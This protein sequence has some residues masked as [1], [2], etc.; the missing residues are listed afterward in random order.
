M[1]IISILLFSNFF[2]ASYLKTNGVDLGKSRVFLGGRSKDDLLCR[3]EFLNM[4]I[5]LQV[6]TDYRTV[7]TELLMQRHGFTDLSYVF[8]E[9]AMGSS[10]GI[11]G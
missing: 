4:G 8:P 1:P 9:F 6:T 5:D 3:N 2:L 10:L 7:L 11:A